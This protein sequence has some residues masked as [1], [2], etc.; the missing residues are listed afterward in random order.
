[1]FDDGEASE[2]G[3][4]SCVDET[5]PQTESLEYCMTK[6]ADGTWAG[7]VGFERQSSSSAAACKWANNR[8]ALEMTVPASQEVN[9]CVENPD[10]TT[11]IY[12]L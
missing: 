1:M 2:F 6:C 9:Y 12:A 4:L 10:T 3:Y 7:C 5:C 8:A 11:N